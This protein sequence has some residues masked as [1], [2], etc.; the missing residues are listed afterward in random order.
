LFTDLRRLDPNT[1]SAQPSPPA[2]EG[3]LNAQDNE[4]LAKVVA[5]NRCV[6]IQSFDGLGVE[7]D[8]QAESQS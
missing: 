5:Q 6:L 7:I 2:Q 8:F 4:V 1:G 3:A